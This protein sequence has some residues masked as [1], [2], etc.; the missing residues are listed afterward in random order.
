LDQGDTNEVILQRRLEILKNLH[1]IN[2]ANAR[3]YMQ[4]AKIQ[5]AIEGD[6]NSKFFHGI[7]NRK[8]ANLAIKV[9]ESLHLSVSRAIEAGIFKGIKIDSTLNLSHLFYADDV[10]FIG[11]WSPSNLSGITNILHCFSL[12]SG[13][14]IN[15]KKSNLLGVGVRSEYV[16]DA[17]VNL[18]CLTMKTPFKYLGVMVGGICATSQAWED[19]IGKLKAR[20]SNWKLKTLS[21]GG[22]LTLLKSV[23]GSTP[24]YNL[25]IYKAPKSVLHSM[26]S[27]RRNFFNEVESFLLENLFHPGSV[28]RKL[29]EINL[30]CLL[31]GHGLH[32]MTDRV[33]NFITDIQIR[34]VI[35]P[36]PNY[37]LPAMYIYH[38]FSERFPLNGLSDKVRSVAK[39]R[40][41][42]FDDDSSREHANVMFGAP[43]FAASAKCNVC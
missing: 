1:D 28:L 15:L 8:R 4:K 14:S 40:Q 39:Q 37:R 34:G 38:Y 22:R 12:L 13:L 19:T 20:L 25:S 5:W 33:I 32:S 7:I 23:L 6:E 18:G 3:D 36:N 24:I 2:S 30:A 21:V 10:V 11:E 43:V 35:D 41:R 26:E 27:L 29:A 31:P 42:A 16:K 9:M 17:A